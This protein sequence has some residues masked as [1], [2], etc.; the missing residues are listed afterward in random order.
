M[1]ILIIGKNSYIG[2]HIDEWLVKSGYTVNQL[3]VLTDVW[4]SFDYS[5]FDAIVHVAGI[6]HRPDCTDWELYKRVNADMPLEIAQKAK[7]QGVKQYIYFSTMGVY[8]I[9]KELRPSIV[10]NDTPLLEEGNSMYGRSKL[11]AEKAL[12]KLHDAT[13]SI[14]IVRPPSVYGKGCTGGYSW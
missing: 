6:V 5:G 9:G 10:R 2:N 7:S 8:E 1:N 14:A 13:F 3:D 12:N 4:K 11:M